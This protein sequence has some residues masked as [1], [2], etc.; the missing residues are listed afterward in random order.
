MMP[1]ALSPAAGDARPPS[2][3]S[4]PAAPDFHQLCHEAA[5]C[6]RCMEHEATE[7]ALGLGVCERCKEIMLAPLSGC[8]LLEVAS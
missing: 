7:H 5:S 8:V 6:E 3:S 1:R 2:P 4:A